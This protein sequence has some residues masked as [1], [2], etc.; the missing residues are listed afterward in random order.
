MTSQKYAYAAFDVHCIH[1]RCGGG[2]K[3]PQFVDMYGSW[4][5]VHEGKRS[6]N[7]FDSSGSRMTCSLPHIHEGLKHVR[8]SRIGCR[9]R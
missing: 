6:L 3:H 8:S 1:D 7:D 5:F 4:S 2:R 9:L